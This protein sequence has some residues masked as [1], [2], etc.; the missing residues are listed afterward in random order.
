MMIIRNHIILF[1]SF[2]LISC[3][4]VENTGSMT[5]K[6]P[7]FLYIYPDGRK[8]FKDRTMNDEDVIIYDDGKG[9]ERAAVKLRIPNYPDVYR[10]SITVERIDVPVK[11]K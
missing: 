8:E 10:D 9:G 7:E 4:L 3:S 5:S 1:A 6:E 2:L 11:R